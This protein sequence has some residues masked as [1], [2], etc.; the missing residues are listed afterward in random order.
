[1]KK[2]KIFFAYKHTNK[3]WG[4]ANNFIR[5]LYGGMINNPDFIIHHD[6]N[7][8]S[9]ILFFSQLSCGPGNVERGS[10]RLYS[11]T[12]V[13]NLKN[14]SK[15]SLVV[16]AVNLNINSSQLKSLKSILLYIKSGLLLDISTIR[17]VNLADFVIFQSEFQRSFFR[18]WGYRGRKNTVIHNGASPVFEN[19]EF[20]IKEAHS[21][22]LMVSNSNHKAFKKHEIVAKMSLIDGVKVIHVGNWSNKIKNHR[23]DIRGTLTHEELVNIYKDADYLLHPAIA[24]PCPNSVIEALHFGLPVIYNSKEGSSEEIVRGNGIAINEEDLQKTVKVA[25]EKIVSLKQ[26]LASGRDYYS[27]KSAV[28]MYVEVFNKFRKQ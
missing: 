11:L 22:L 27:I 12:E 24:D 14:K 19:N 9:D 1:M 20:S 6:I 7:F 26:K 8:D 10:K 13:K 3:P 23:V 4:G 16:R 17:L 25:R 15:A 18:R 2:T 28:S 5:A 21:P